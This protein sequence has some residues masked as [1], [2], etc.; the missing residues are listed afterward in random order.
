MS[1]R[2]DGACRADVPGLLASGLAQAGC[3]NHFAGFS[4]AM[5]IGTGRVA[6]RAAIRELDN[7]PPPRLDTAEI[8]AL[9]A[10]AA[11]PLEETAT[12]QSDRLLRELQTIMFDCE[13]SIWKHEE[14]LG[15]ALG[16]IE[17]LG[18]EVAALGAPDTHELVRLKETEAMVLAA[19]IILRASLMR[20]ET[21]LSHFREDYETRND[22]DWLAWIDATEK[23]GAPSLA[24]TPIPTPLVDAAGP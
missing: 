6:G 5:C 2:T 24:K 9:E 14:R 17:A 8:T 11:A 20:T 19:G 21:R 10:E 1:L 13:I 22:A 15:E 18:D 3:A 23:N 12:A 7:L 4:I 16:R